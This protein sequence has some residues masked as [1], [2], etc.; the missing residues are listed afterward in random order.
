MESRPEDAATRDATLEAIRI[1]IRIE[2]DEAI[3]A[4]TD[5]DTRIATDTATG[6]LVDASTR[7]ATDA[8]TDDA[9][10]AATAPHLTMVNHTS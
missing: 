5:I 4:A 6:V 7:A 8:A 3:W 9:I 10:R 1:A 2:V